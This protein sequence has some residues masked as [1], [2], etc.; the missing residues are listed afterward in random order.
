MII[1]ELSLQ[2]LGKFI[3]EWFNCDTILFYLFQF[4]KIL[5]INDWSYLILKYNFIT[6]CRTHKKINFFLIVT[7][8]ELKTK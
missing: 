4:E 7:I 1:K 2:I 8:K 5:F 6:F 3:R